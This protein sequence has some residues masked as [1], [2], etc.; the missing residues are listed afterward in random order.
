VLSEVAPQ[1]AESEVVA[2][3]ENNEF[4][5]DIPQAELENQNIY[6]NQQPEVV[7]NNIE[8]QPEEQPQID[9]RSEIGNNAV[10]SEM[11][12]VNVETSEINITTPVKLSDVSSNQV[13]SNQSETEGQVQST[14]SLDQILDSE[15][16]SNPQYTD[17]SK[18][19]PQNIPAS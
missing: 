12:D 15:L 7:E 13:E 2:S 14:L 18:A 11:N 19:S 6:E 16:L 9:E 5:S 1:E 10:A 17:N 3:V 8:I 4:L